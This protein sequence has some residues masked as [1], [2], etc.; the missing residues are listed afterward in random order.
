M[1][2]KLKSDLYVGPVDI[3]LISD[4]VCPHMLEYRFFTNHRQVLCCDSVVL[5]INLSA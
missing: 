5:F 3:V 1:T 2:L 4:T